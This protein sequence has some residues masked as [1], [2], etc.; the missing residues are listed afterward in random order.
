MHVQD[1]VNHARK[2]WFVVMNATTRAIL[3]YLAL[4]ISHA[5]AQAQPASAPPEPALAQRAPHSDLR[6]VDKYIESAMR[7]HHI[8]GVSLAIGRH[9]KVVLAK[10]YGQANVELSVPATEDT[11]YQ[12]ASVT[13]TFT[14]TA[15]MMLVEEGKLRLDDKVTKHLSDLPKAWEAVTVYHLLNHTS[16]IKSYTNVENFFKMSRKD[17]S[18]HEILGL[19]TNEPLEFV[20][21]EKWN[22]SN[23]GF[24]LLGMLIEKVTG[25]TYGEFL[26]GRI[27]QPVG[28][29]H[30][31]TNDLH[32]IIPNRAQGYTWNGQELRIGE[33]V[34]PSQP[35]SAGMLVSSVND[36][37]KWDAALDSETL[38][39]KST[40]A[41][42]WTPSPLS[43]RAE[44]EYG[45]GWEIGKVNGHRVVS[46]SGGIPGFR[47]DISRFVDDKLT[48]IVL[49]NS[50]Q[51]GN[52]GALARGIASRIE[53]TLKKKPEK[54]IADTDP[55]TSERLKNLF[56]EIM[57]GE[58]DPE[59]FTED[60]RKDLIPRLQR[61]GKEGRFS[62]CGALKTFGLL[63]RNETEAGIN[64]RYRTA[65][66]NMTAE[67]TFALQKNGKIAN[68]DFRPSED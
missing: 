56:V 59:L 8:P 25:K 53:P 33:Y 52:A 5:Q 11:V 6:S 17:Y 13:K 49:A 45:L 35:F 20:P 4:A 67:T 39:N 7:D 41:H 31:R 27:F 58:V 14:A 37:L 3:S 12:L 16:G 68:I 21:G 1:T 55:K 46:H 51:G 2:D 19:V 48:V 57:K 43:K 32:A 36:L 65:F 34:S 15:I 26:E 18:H 28:M 10:G 60:A 63:E 44:T 66:E 61:A 62:P 40:L 9:G 42:M 22:Y 24:F 38:L 23:S 30:T 50:D 47:A 29:T 54:P 64:L